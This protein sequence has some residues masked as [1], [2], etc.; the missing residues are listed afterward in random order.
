MHP[1]GCSD[2]VEVRNAM[3]EEPDE[4]WRE[5]F[6]ALPVVTVS[7]L[8]ADFPKSY[9][10]Y[11]RGYPSA[12]TVTGQL[13]LIGPDEKMPSVEYMYETGLIPADIA[14]GMAKFWQEYVHR[15]R[16]ACF[17]MEEPLSPSQIQII[18]QVLT[19]VTPED[20]VSHSWDWFYLSPPFQSLFARAIWLNRSL[21]QDRLLGN[22]L[23][24]C[25][26]PNSLYT[27]PLEVTGWVTPPFWGTTLCLDD[28]RRV[29]VP[30]HTF[31]ESQV[32]RTEFYWI[33]Q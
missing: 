30:Q 18:R 15:G 1:A 9:A 7:E 20:D 3:D 23:L 28:I 25:L 12:I 11:P 10:R 16:F 27:V 33:P 4:D 19:E 21:L 5:Y 17:L 31:N 24:Q 14:P 13:V 29:A 6:D 32:E 8:V 22:Y 2:Q 26:E